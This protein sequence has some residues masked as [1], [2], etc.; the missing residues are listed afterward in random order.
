MKILNSIDNSKILPERKKVFL[1]SLPKAG[2]NLAAK[3]LELMGYRQVGGVD[4]SII[5][6]RGLP[7]ILRRWYF[8]P[9]KSSPCYLVG[10][11]MPVE[12]SCK[13]VAR[14]LNRAK[15]G[16]FIP[17][18]VGYKPELLGMIKSKGFAP[19]LIL[20]DPRAVLNS[21]VHYVVANAFHP[22]HTF[23]KNKSTEE[24]YRFALHG[25]RDTQSHL[26]PLLTRCRAVDVWKSDPAV[27]S[28]RFEDLVGLP[29]G[30]SKES[31]ERSLHALISFLGIQGITIQD[32]ADDIFGP[33]R[34]TFRK[35]KIRGWEREMPTSLRNEV[36][37]VLGELLI[38]WGYP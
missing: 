3:C 9:A 22:L 8:R 25:I 33:G 23:F 21:F 29:G 10:I 30:G 38:D 31:Q 1:N 4:A 12:L 24:R 18:H 15:S 28:L 36:D 26:Q 19:V 2:T 35:G 27:L 16:N 14:I 13:A 5:S 32:I 7:S 17:G 11:D 20:R 6:R 37:E 34:H